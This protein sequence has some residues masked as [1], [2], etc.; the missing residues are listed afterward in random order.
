MIVNASLNQARICT[1]KAVTLTMHYEDIL[2]KI[3]HFGK[4]QKFLVIVV[5]MT[6]LPG[7]C[8]FLAQ[9][10][11]AADTDHWCLIPASQAVNCSLLQLDSVS[12]CQEAQKNQSIPYELD[13]QGSRVYSSCERYVFEDEEDGDQTTNSTDVIDCDAGWDFDRLRY[14]STINE[15]FRLVCERED[16]VGLAQS[17]WFAGVLTGSL[18]WGSV[19]DW[20]GRRKTF[21]LSLIFVSIS[22]IATTF[23]PN[24]LAY[25]AL[26]FVTAACAYGIMLIISILPTEI[27]GPKDR[28]K[29]GTVSAIFFALGYLLLSFCAYF[30]RDWRHLQLVISLPYLLCFL[31]LIILPESPRWLISKGRFKEAKKIITKI[32]KVNGTKVPDNLL[33]TLESLREEDE[34]SSPVRRTTILDLFRTPNIRKKT[35]IMFYAWFVASMVYYG[36]SLSTSSLGIDDYVAAFVSGALEIP[37][38]LMCWFVMEKYGRRFTMFAF[39]MFGGLF[40]LATIFVP[41]GAGRVAVAMTGKFA[42]TAAFNH[43]YI[44]TCEIHPTVVRSIGL[45]AS[46]MAARVSGVLCPII[47]ILGKYWQPLPLCVFG[48]SSVLAGMLSLMLPETLGRDMPDTLQD[49]EKV[50]MGWSP[51][52]CKTDSF[53]SSDSSKLPADFLLLSSTDKSTTEPAVV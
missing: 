33:G 8:Q 39:F 29:V 41:L 36:L 51:G 15:E 12:A 34:K 38:Y 27:V 37:S 17:V 7:A 4:Y 35:L 26:R 10:F 1:L 22:S 13:S 5:S 2:H 48:G 21:I 3:G 45:G 6:Q 47:L 23:A 16:F 49:G 28:V 52:C 42:I 32:A 19:G 44:Y 20:L 18:V 43:I 53:D 11:L 9:V 31:M 50:A 25:M 40:C 24:F 14:K 30:I 46:S